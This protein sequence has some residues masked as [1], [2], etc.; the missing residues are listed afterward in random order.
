M[1]CIVVK[2]NSSQDVEGA[3]DP[4]CARSVRH[5]LELG[6]WNIQPVCNYVEHPGVVVACA[7]C[8][9]PLKLH[10]MDEVANPVEGPMWFPDSHGD[11][12]RWV[13]WTR[14]FQPGQQQVDYDSEDPDDDWEHEEVDDPEW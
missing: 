1:G 8:H 4:V 14:R 6:L 11:L 3:T 5:I 13:V 7:M 9:E 10:A 2:A 12:A